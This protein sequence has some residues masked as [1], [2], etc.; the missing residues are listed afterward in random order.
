MPVFYIFYWAAGWVVVLSH[1]PPMGDPRPAHGSTLCL[2]STFITGQLGGRWFFPYHVV[3]LAR[4]I[5]ILSMYVYI[6]LRIFILLNFF[7]GFFETPPY[8]IIARLAGGFITI[9]PCPCKYIT[10]KSG[11]LCL[12]S[13]FFTG[14][15]GGC[16][17]SP[18]SRP[19]TWHASPGP[20]IF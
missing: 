13:T 14:Q 7:F 5:Y 10:L 6:F 9:A 8:T 15:V 18:I 19:S 20:Y 4:P 2:Y 11:T 1:V 17:F 3:R 16:W 12:Y